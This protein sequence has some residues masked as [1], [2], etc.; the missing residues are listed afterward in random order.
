MII[1]AWKTIKF[2]T[3]VSIKLRKVVLGLRSL[4]VECERDKVLG[5]SGP[6]AAGKQ[7]SLS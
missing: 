1:E 2:I 4:L 7:S 5:I 6:G 3:L